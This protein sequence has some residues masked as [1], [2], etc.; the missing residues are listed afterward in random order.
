M[1][2]DSFKKAFKYVLIIIFSVIVLLGFTGCQ[3]KGYS[4]KRV[5]LYTVAVNSIL[6][7]NG[8]SYL[9]ERVTDP[10]IE[11]I[12]EDEFGRTLFTYYEKYYSE[13]TFSSLI[14]SQGSIEGEVY[15]YEDCNLLV[16]QQEP[17]SKQLEKFSSDEINYLKAVNDW[18]ETLDL[19]K[20]VKKKI[21]KHKQSI[22]VD[23]KIF[24][25]KAASHFNFI[26]KSFYLQLDY[27]TCDANNN[28][29]VYG[30]FSGEEDIFFAAMLTPDNEIIDCFIPTDP[31]NYQS[32]FK[33]FKAKNG[34]S[35]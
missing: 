32:E 28:Y 31:Y 17:Y 33:D 13:I 1:I 3:Y 19:N 7:N 21:D 24:S 25:D 6:W 2:A 30:V 26:D 34:W 5:D 20:C 18:G 9:T 15:Y 10:K 23:E 27:L 16:K 8:Y 22:P 35:N 12:E 11:V 14:I 4:G 29:V